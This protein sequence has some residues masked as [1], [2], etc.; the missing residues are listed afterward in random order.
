MKEKLLNVLLYIAI[1]TCIIVS[2]VILFFNGSFGYFIYILT[3]GEQQ[4]TYIF[5]TIGLIGALLAL[6][7]LLFHKNAGKFYYLVLLGANSVVI[8]YPYMFDAI[9]THIFPKFI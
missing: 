6:I 3:L 7:P 5:S 1:Y 8:F 9:A 4:G 2:T